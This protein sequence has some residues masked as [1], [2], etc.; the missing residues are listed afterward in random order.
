MRTN[1]PSVDHWAEIGDGE[2]LV[3]FFEDSQA[4][5]ESLEGFI[6]GGVRGKSAG[7]VIASREHLD[8]LEQQLAAGGIDMAAAKQS[9]QYV[10]VEA[11]QLLGQILANRW[12]QP[13]LFRIKV[14]G[15]I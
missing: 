13:D 3:Q 7:I 2:H 11:S 4:L 14:G 10:P 12:P 5:L 6:G 9:G 15:L 8:A 1:A